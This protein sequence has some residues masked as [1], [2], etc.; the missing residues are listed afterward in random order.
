M[1]L[2]DTSVAVDYLRGHPPATVL[3][4]ELLSTEEEVVASE[5]TRFELVA[6]VRDPE[7][8]D[9]EAFFIALGWVPVTEEVT[10]A[11]GDLAR[12]YRRNRASIDDIDYLIAATATSIAADLLTTNVRHFPMFEG[13]A[14]PY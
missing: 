10:R 5:L 8:E 9:L 1:K 14:P 7:I 12:R 6:G 13:I 4:D 3:I 11:A 2:I